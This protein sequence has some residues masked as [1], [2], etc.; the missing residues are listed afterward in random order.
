MGP[1]LVRCG[2]LCHPP[3]AFYNVQY[4]QWGRNLFVAESWRIWTAGDPA[5]GTFNGAATCSLRKVSLNALLPADYR[6]P[7][8]GP[9]LV[10][11]GKAAVMAF[12]RLGGAP[13][14]G[15]QLVRCG[16]MEGMSPE[17]IALALQWGR[18]LFV[19]ESRT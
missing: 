16:K 12:Y 17:Y 4:L 5:G 14:M 11:C 6:L 15:P 19:A 9:Q 18:N 10:R 2:K 3:I 13:S 7:S 8:M 1:Q